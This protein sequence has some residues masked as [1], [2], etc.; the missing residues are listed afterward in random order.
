[1]PLAALCEQG[2]GMTRRK[3]LAKGIIRRKK[4]DGQ[5][6]TAADKARNCA[7]HGQSLTHK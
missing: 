3:R 4:T 6:L 7:D 5:P 1:V 2:L